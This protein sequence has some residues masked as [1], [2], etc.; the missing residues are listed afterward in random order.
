MED[1]SLLQSSP[2]LME[3]KTNTQDPW[4]THLFDC[5]S[6]GRS[7]C[8]WGF[9]CPICLFHQGETY[10]VD[11]K[12]SS[13]EFYSDPFT[14]SQL[15]RY[16]PWSCR[17][18]HWFL[19]GIFLLGSCFCVPPLFG[20]VVGCG[21]HQRYSEH[22]RF[23]HH[24]SSLH[25]C[26]KFSCFHDCDAILIED[27]LIGYFCCCCSIIQV[28]MANEEHFRMRSQVKGDINIKRAL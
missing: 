11:L 10:K 1:Q 22:D 24:C 6:G 8:L 16:P 25:C 14:E 12:Y 3:E 23:G 21:R 18:L 27:V 19:I 5:C 9:L 15:E 2:L 28:T 17:G 4:P 7:L 26:P 13:P 20:I